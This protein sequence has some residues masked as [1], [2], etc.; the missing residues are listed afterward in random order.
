[1]TKIYGRT[2][3]ADVEKLV[4]GSLVVDIELGRIREEIPEAAL[5]GVLDIE[6]EQGGGMAL[7]PIPIDEAIEY[8]GLADPAFAPLGENHS[9]LFAHGM[10][11]LLKAARKRSRE[12]ARLG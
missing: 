5:V 7:L 1:V 10:I 3:A 6:I 2:L 11:L 9:C 8:L 4:E 12:P